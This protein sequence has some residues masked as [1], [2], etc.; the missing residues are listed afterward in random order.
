M[1]L[2]LLRHAHKGLTPFEDPDL[3]TKGFEQAQI[4]ADLVATNKLPKPTQCLYSDKIRTRQTLAQVVE[5]WAP[6]CLRKPELNMRSHKETQSEFRGRIQK[7]CSQLVSQSKFSDVCFL[8]THYDWI[9][10]VLTL[11]NSDKDLNSFEY[12]NWSP[13]QYLVFE[14]SKEAV[15][16]WIVMQKGVLA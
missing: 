15:A 10:E 2:I 3:S 8:C 5:T 1:I 6:I 4:L 12:L 9:E 13:G 14:I 16:P 7:F 11:I